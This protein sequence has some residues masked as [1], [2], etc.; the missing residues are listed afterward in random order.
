MDFLIG[1]LFGDYI[2][3]NDW[4]AN[5]KKQKNALGAIACSIHCVLWSISVLLFTGWHCQTVRGNIVLGILLFASHYVID[6]TNFVRWFMDKTKK[7]VM[8][9][10][11]GDFW[12]L[13]VVDNTIH[14]LCL[15]LIQK[16]VI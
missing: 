13:I 7:F 4:L 3:Q 14:L 8:A 1:H 6:R 2:L 9:R 12:S 16:F 10:E 11:K 15:W 5:H